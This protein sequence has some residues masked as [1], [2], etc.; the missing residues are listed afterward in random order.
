MSFKNSLDSPKQSEKPQSQFYGRKL[1]RPIKGERKA[2]LEAKLPKLKFSRADLAAAANLCPSSLFHANHLM[3]WMEI[4]FGDGKHLKGMMDQHPD[5]NFIGAEPFINGMS[6]FLK[7]IDTADETRLRV[8]MD[9]AME[10]VRAL[11]SSSIERLYILNPDPWH[12][13]RHHKRRIVNPENLNEFARILKPEGLL[14]MSTDVPYL[15]EW[16]LTHT[17]NHPEFLWTAQTIKDCLQP[18]EN[19][20]TTTY[21]T[22]RA[23]GAD[24]MSYLIFKKTLA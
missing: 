13:K 14:V 24:K 2:A 3:T 16:M 15:A 5:V 8:H 21:E 9:D 19:W 7:L 18:P 6:T 17:F 20:I 22:K 11:K 23:K 1:G 10:V 4:G 12:K